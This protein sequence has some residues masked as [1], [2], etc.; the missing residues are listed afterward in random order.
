MSFLDLNL[1]DVPSLDA[2][3]AGEYE[4]RIVEVEIKTSK[5]T[6]G[7]MIL[8]R[9]DIPSEPAS[10]DLTHVMML[11]TAA[12]DEKK[13]VR[14]LQAIKEFCDAFG[15]DYSKGLSL[16]NPEGLTAWAI[17]GIEETDEYGRQNRVKRF[18]HSR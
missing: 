6:G 9:L 10:K 3:E 8:C 7:E 13:K 2:V 12:D 1:N 5:N 4:V 14:R 17:L 15:I 18:I 16:H 11:P